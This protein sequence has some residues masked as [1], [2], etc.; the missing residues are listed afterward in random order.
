MRY[1]PPTRRVEI[2]LASFAAEHLGGVLAGFRF[3][4][5][6]TIEG[7]LKWPRSDPIARTDASTAS[8]IFVTGC[9]ACPRM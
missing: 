9:V 4:G 6:D 2:I 1:R 8:M 5:F 3:L 7:T